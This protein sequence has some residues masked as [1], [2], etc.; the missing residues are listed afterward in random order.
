MLFFYNSGW[1]LF[2]PDCHVAIAVYFFNNSGWVLFISDCDLDVPVWFFFFTTLDGCC[3]FLIVSWLSLF[4]SFTTL[5]ECCLFLIV[6]WPS[7]FIFLQLWMGAIYFY[8]SSGHRWC[9]FYNSGWAPFIPN[10]PLA[11]PCGMAW[12]PSSQAIHIVQCT[13]HVNC[14]CFTMYWARAPL[15][16]CKH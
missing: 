3:L 7:H 8:L 9:F 11:T 15:P 12:T 2:I 13:G 4:I 5:D 14:G 16:N 6:M 10:S 1:V